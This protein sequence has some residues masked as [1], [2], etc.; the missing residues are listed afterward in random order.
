MY[1]D[2]STMSKGD[3]LTRKQNNKTKMDKVKNT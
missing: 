2:K 3:G 1:N